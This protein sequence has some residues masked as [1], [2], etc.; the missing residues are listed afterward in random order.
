VALRYSLVDKTVERAS[1]KIVEGS[2]TPSEVTDVWTFVRR[3]GG[4]WELSAIQAT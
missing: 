1:G 2:E 3:P 4:T